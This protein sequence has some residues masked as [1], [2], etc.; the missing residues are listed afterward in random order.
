MRDAAE[1]NA[2]AAQP[3]PVPQLDPEVLAARSLAPRPVGDALA[4]VAR[5]A[6]LLL[7]GEEAGRLKECAREDCTLLFVDGSRS[8][9]RRWRSMDACGNRA[10]TVAYRRRRAARYD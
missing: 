6:V 8:G 9:R 10:K 5:D 4:A 1:V 7:G 2:W 3:G